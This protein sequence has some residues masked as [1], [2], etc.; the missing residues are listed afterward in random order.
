MTKHPLAPLTDGIWPPPYSTYT[1]FKEVNGVFDLSEFSSKKSQFI[2]VEWDGIKLTATEICFPYKTKTSDPANAEKL[3][4]LADFMRV[5][6]VRTGE[7]VMV[8]DDTQ[9]FTD[10]RIL[11]YHRVDVVL[12]W[13]ESLV[14]SIEYVA[15]K[16]GEWVPENPK[17]NPMYYS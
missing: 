11:D 2:H 10:L 8:A 4:H 5:M 3:M 9:V 1:T 12:P 13:D 15:F 17:V 7:V 6:N 14:Y 16:D